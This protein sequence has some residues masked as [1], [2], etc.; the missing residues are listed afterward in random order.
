MP[1]YR[2][3]MPLCV[4]WLDGQNVAVFDGAGTGVPEELCRFIGEGW[5]GYWRGWGWA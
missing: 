1:I 2:P 4:A 3:A 5:H